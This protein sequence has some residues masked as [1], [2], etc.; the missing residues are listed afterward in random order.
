[1]QRQVLSANTFVLRFPNQRG[2]TKESVDSEANCAFYCSRRNNR[3]ISN[4]ILANCTPLG[5]IIT[6]SVASTYFKTFT[7]L[8]HTFLYFYAVLRHKT[9]N[10][11]VLEEEHKNRFPFCNHARTSFR[12]CRRFDYSFVGPFEETENSSSSTSSSSWTTRSFVAF[13]SVLI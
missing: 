4:Y 11:K 5:T 1:M 6:W 7:G 3:F 13:G 12:M 8:S 2:L 10:G 9:S